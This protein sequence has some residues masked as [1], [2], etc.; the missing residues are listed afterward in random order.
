MKVIC[1]LDNWNDVT[2][3][4]ALA[5]IGKHVSLLDGETYLDIGKEYTVY[6]IVFWDSAPWFL[7]Q[8]ELN[9][10]YPEP[11]PQELFEVSCPRLSSCWRL[12]THVFRFDGAVSFLVLP[13]W[14]N[15]PA[16]Y[17]RLVDGEPEE[18]AIYNKYR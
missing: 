11:F 13:E 14:A 5:R 6:G 4:E 12:S 7:L 9:L 1:R 17:E 2:E 3:P 10:E 15:N 8:N 18:I 16:F